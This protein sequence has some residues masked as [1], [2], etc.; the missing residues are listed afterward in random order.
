MVSISALD[1]RDLAPADGVD[2]GR[3]QPGGRA[4]LQR[5]GV[6]VRALRQPP[7]AGIIGR[8][9]KLLREHCAHAPVCRD[10]GRPHFLLGGGDEFGSLFRRHGRAESG[11]AL[12]QGGDQ[13][14][15]RRLRRRETV[16]LLDHALQNEAR[17][18]HSRRGGGFRLGDALVD[19]RC[20]EGEAGEVVLDVAGVADRMRRGEEIHEPE[21]QSVELLEDETVPGEGRAADGILERPPDHRR[22]GPL[23]RR[24]RG[25]RKTLQLLQTPARKLGALPGGLDAIGP[26]E[27]SAEDQLAVERILLGACEVLGARGTL[28]A[29]ADPVGCELVGPLVKGGIGR[30]SGQGREREQAG[31]QSEAA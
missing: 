31:Q 21:V 14:I 9:G 18:N 7:Y 16:E 29:G 1:A 22:G 11:D 30:A 10:D 3:R 24:E 25:R 4:R 23:L 8:S 12:V 15:V 17:R 20:D 2:L 13:G 19:A 26:A 27:R 6:K 5:T 28:R